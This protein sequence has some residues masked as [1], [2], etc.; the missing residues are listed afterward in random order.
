[1]DAQDLLKDMGASAF[2]PLPAEPAL[3]RQQVRQLLEEPVVSKG[4][5]AWMVSANDSEIERI[6]AVFIERGWQVHGWLSGVQMQSASAGLP[7]PDI[8]IVDP[9]LSDLPTDDILTWC[10]R[11]CPEAMCIV[12]GPS[13]GRRS[14]SSVTAMSV[15]SLPKSCDSF[16]LM[17]FCE[18]W[19]WERA[20]SRVEG[21][22]EVRT[23][24]LKE[25]EAQFR[26]LFEI[27]P[28]VLVIHDAQ[29]GHT[30]RPP[31]CFAGNPI[32]VTSAARHGTG[33]EPI[34]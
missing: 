30:G 4:F 1:M 26:G 19:R 11:E 24:D 25:S 27:L 12:M 20:L 7:S 29:P 23:N 6:R 34:S 17:A 33:G 21:I 5:Q 9:P 18:K 10:M 32:S 8:V 16:T 28:D 3:I 31:R 13:D 14:S 2:L 15:V 22:L